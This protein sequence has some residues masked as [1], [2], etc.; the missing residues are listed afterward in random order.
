MQ[1]RYNLRKLW[2]PMLK[3]MA[4]LLPDD[5]LWMIYGLSQLG[6]S[7]RYPDQEATT[8]L[9][10]CSHPRPHPCPRPSY[11]TYPENQEADQ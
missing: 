10:L 11:C 5:L 9:V 1:T 7:H 4:L 6:P 2:D 8:A 3:K